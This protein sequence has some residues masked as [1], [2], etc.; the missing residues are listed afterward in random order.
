MRLTNFLLTILIGIIF[1]QNSFQK[2][3]NNVKE[4]KQEK[5]PVISINKIPIT[6]YKTIIPKIKEG[7]NEWKHSTTFRQYSDSDGRSTT[8]I[9]HNIRIGK[10]YYISS[11]I[12][13]RQSYYG[14]D[15]F[16]GD[17]SITKYW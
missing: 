10:D 14:E 6:Q 17:F 2:L 12:S 15:E 9:N 5:E 4:V 1:F 11:G 13:Y 7:K 8:G 16:G 3:N